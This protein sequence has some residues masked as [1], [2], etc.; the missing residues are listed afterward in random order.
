VTD[1]ERRMARKPL[2]EILKSQLNPD[3]RETLG[4]LKKFGWALHFVRHDPELSW[5]PHE[6]NC[7]SA[8]W[9]FISLVS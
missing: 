1:E 9:T 8:T 5:L 4:E 7:S 6:G 2:P 3:Q